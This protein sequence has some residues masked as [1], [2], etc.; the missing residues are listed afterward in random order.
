MRIYNQAPPKLAEA[1][2]K[3]GKLEC[4]AARSACPN[5]HALNPDVGGLD[6]REVCFLAGCIRSESQNRLA[7]D[8]A[9]SLSMQRSAA[10]AA[11]H[12]CKTK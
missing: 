4:D 5:P 7:P 6:S 12:P 2:P 10:E 3:R 1:D 11:K 8:A 9:R